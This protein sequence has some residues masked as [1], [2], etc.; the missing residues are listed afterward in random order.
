[1]GRVK[2]ICNKKLDFLFCKSVIHNGNSCYSVIHRKEAN[3]WYRSLRKMDSLK[4]QMMVR[5]RKTLFKF[6]I[7]ACGNRWPPKIHRHHHS[8]PGNVLKALAQY[9][10]FHA[11]TRKEKKR[12]VKVDFAAAISIYLERSLDGSEHVNIQYGGCSTFCMQ[13]PRNIKTASGPLYND[14]TIQS[15]G[16]FEDNIR[17]EL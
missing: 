1:M 2:R 3:G 7:I 17:Y 6:T 12:R 11:S 5:L 10:L 16:F 14:I 4:V 13:S 15:N 9:H 8:T